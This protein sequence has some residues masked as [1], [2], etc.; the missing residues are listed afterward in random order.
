M[1]DCWNKLFVLELLF[2]CMQILDQ[3]VPLVA[4]P[5]TTLPILCFCIYIFMFIIWVIIILICSWCCCCCCCCLSFCCCIMVAICCCS[6]DMAGSKGKFVF[7]KGE[8]DVATPGA[9]FT[10][11]GADRGSW[12]C[13]N[14]HSAPWL[15]LLLHMFVRKYLHTILLGC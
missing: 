11:F 5:I 8:T 2:W 15:L 13:L 12:S 7:H 10:T 4:D 9:A 1:S 14:Q 6:P 3:V